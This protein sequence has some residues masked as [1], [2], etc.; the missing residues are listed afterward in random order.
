MARP[1]AEVDDGSTMFTAVRDSCGLPA[2]SIGDGGTTLILDGAGNDGT[3]GLPIEDIGCALGAIDAPDSIV[4]QME[5]TR[6]LDGR[7]SA[8]SEGYT[9]SW[10]YHPDSGLDITITDA[11]QD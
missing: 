4:T 8:D 3:A 6:A 9:Y 11:W 10:I 5:Q 1:E 7:Q 2:S